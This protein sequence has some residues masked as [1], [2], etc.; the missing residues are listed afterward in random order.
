MSPL[1]IVAVSIRTVQLMQLKVCNKN[2]TMMQPMI[3]NQKALTWLCVLSFDKETK[4]QKCFYFLFSF[5]F[6]ISLIF[7]VA[8]SAAFFVR[9]VSVDLEL[10]LHSVF[11]IAAGKAHTL[12][13]LQTIFATTV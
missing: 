12:R 1:S 4:K 9:Y 13:A 5:V 11:Q 3:T 8:N 10:T 7:S 6:Y 2:S